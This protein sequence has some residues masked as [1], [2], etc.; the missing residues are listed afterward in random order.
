MQWYCDTDSKKSLIKI[1]TPLGDYFS[2]RLNNDKEFI[3]SNFIS[4]FIKMFY[5]DSFLIPLEVNFF[6]GS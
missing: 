1:F 4:F 2:H 3:Q 6:G 5:C